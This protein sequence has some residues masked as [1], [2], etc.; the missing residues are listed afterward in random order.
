MSNAKL[1][2]LNKAVSAIATN[3]EA[4]L[5]KSKKVKSK[6]VEIVCEEKD[7][8][9][10]SS[11]NI[12]ES[13]KT[14][15]KKDDIVYKKL[16][17]HDQMLM[18]PD[19]YIGSVK[20]ARTSEPVFLLRRTASGTGTMASG[21]PYIVKDY[22][23]YPDGLIR[24][25]MEILSNAIDNVWRSVTTEGCN[26]T[27]IKI[28]IDRENGGVKVWNDGRNIPVEMHQTEKVYIPEMIFGHLLTSSNYNDGEER[29]TS[30]L[31]GVGAKASSVFSTKMNITIYNKAAGILYEQGWK[32]NMYEKGE[33][34]L[35]KITSKNNNYKTVEDGKNGF[36]QVEFFPD[37]SRFGLTRFT[38]DVIAI[39]EKLVYD[40]A[41]TVSMNKVKVQYNG[42]DIPVK[43]IKDYVKLYFANEKVT[44]TE[45]ESMSDDEELKLVDEPEP[46]PE[47]KKNKKKEIDEGVPSEHLLLASDDCR[48]MVCQTNCGEFTH[49]SFVNG[50]YTKYGGAHVDKW[51][52]ALFRPL[53]EK[54]NDNKKR[55]QIDI[56]DV[57][58]HFFI[59]VYASIDKPSFD[60]QSKNKLSDVPI[61][62]NVKKT[63]IAKMSK[64]EFMEKIENS[65]KMKEMLSLK[66]TERKKRGNVKVEGLD[67]AN[68]AGQKG[69]SQDCI[70]ALTEGLSAKTY[71]V[72]GMKYGING[73][74]G[75]DYI[76]VLPIRGKF[77]NVR[78]SSIET[79]IKNKEVKALIQALGLQYD[80]D[81]SVNE[82][83]N[84]LR[85]GKLLAVVDADSVTG[86]TPLLLKKDEMIEIKTIDDISEGEWISE[87]EKQYNKTSYQVWTEKGWTQIKHVMKHRT[88]KKLYRVVTHTGIVDVTEDHSLLRENGEE[89]EPTKIAINERLLHSYP[90]FTE[91]KKDI[92][93]KNIEDFKSIELQS[94]LRDHKIFGGGRYKKEEAF[95]KIQEIKNATYE[96]L[97]KDFKI[98][99]NE[100]WVMGFFWADGTCGVYK[101]QLRR[102]PKNRPNVYTLN[103]TNYSWC[104]SNTNIK[105]LEK[106]KIILE[107][108][109]PEYVWTIVEDRSN[110]KKGGNCKMAYRLICNGG[111][112]TEPII[113]KY[114]TLFYDSNK[115]KKIP[116]EILNAT[117]EIRSNFLEGYLYGDGN[118]ESDGETLKTNEIKFDIDGKIGASGIFF[119]CRSLGYLVS[120]NTRESKPKICSLNI[121]KGTQ[122]DHPNRIKKIIELGE[123]ETD[124]YDLETENHHFQAGVG[125]MIVH[126]T[127]G[128][129][130]NGLLMN[131]FHFLFPTLLKRNDFFYLMRVPILK[132][133][134]G[135]QILSFFYQ[136]EAQKYIEENKI[137]KDNIKYYKG[138]GTAN[139]DDI[140]QDF[141]RRL[142]QFNSDEKSD[143]LMEKIFGKENT[144]FRKDWISKYL[145]NEEE[146]KYPQIKDFSFEEKT[147][148]DYLNEEL[149]NF[150]IDDCHR[151]IP[152]MLDGFKES[153]RKVI[154]AA[155]KRP[156]RFSGKTLKVAQFAGYVAETSNYHH[157]EQNLYDTITKLAQRFVGSNNIPLL[158]NDGQ[159]GER[160]KNG[161]D[162]ANGR[163]IFTKLDALTR[164]IFREE[165]DT[166]LKNREDDGD[167]VE[168][169]H[170]LPIVP[171]ILVNGCSAGIGTGWSTSVPQYDVKQIIQAIKEWLK[172]GVET[173]LVPWYRNFK[174]EIKV[175]GTKIKTT[176]IVTIN[177]GE[178]RITE[179][180]LGRKNLSI[181]RYKDILEELKEK[182]KIKTIKD[183]ST[184]ANPDFVVVCEK[185][186]ELTVDDLQLID[187][188]STSNMVLFDSKG[189]IHRYENVE[190]ILE[191]FCETRL[192]LYKIRKEGVI[193]EFERELKY[194]RNKIRF[195]GEVVNSTISLKNR[196]DDDLHSELVQKKYDPLL[197]ED[198]NSELDFSYLLNI[199]VRSMTGQRLK[200]LQ[201]KE[202]KMQKELDEYRKKSEK[203]LWIGELDELS[204]EYDKW[205][206]TQVQEVKVTDVKKKVTKSKK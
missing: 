165:D 197:S 2:K 192:N 14:E 4:E 156:L 98:T 125:Q 73:K 70:C 168:K 180:P 46:S 111:I 136:Q 92:P 22:A 175:D 79:L 134:K 77:L 201:D 185:D 143:V 80:V 186:Q 11:V 205:V 85:Y 20:N 41:M 62:V 86:D 188:I 167:I 24:I 26:P 121:T 81:Y 184:E 59:F 10:T 135:K 63:D 203:D 196:T 16:Q 145:Q 87:G 124:V 15:K 39:Y 157:G 101:Y 48:V 64:W 126:N 123:I 146:Q 119:L 76:G 151:S 49:V 191:E 94:I 159:F 144:D 204:T 17:L 199:Q 50:I 139:D 173:K 95:K 27:L 118:K 107:E 84:K 194:L 65:L 174:G 120:V 30:G 177:S 58:K 43:S 153:H 54:L 108:I 61:Q 187:T 88:T 19:T 195:I 148:S 152:N 31:N 110:H 97:Q 114:R 162:A 149:I 104:I 170:Y 128:H 178:Y 28:W 166:F 160:I 38:D 9:E 164:L 18:R 3:K 122:Q 42:S 103:R 133:Q 93:D 23:T 56:R 55:Q 25:F 100:A 36:T 69:K 202:K 106:S 155:F 74:G 138:L 132:I 5:T 189:K 99:P 198:D 91:N 21:T 34:V 45:P 78:N 147:I 66:N 60:S 109:Y 57:K 193:K 176:G 141:G 83:F 52:E 150:S 171:M 105:Y 102:K 190:E 181:A 154:Y 44:E 96:N 172:G 163:Y 67:D 117:T 89:I 32:R 53:V 179:I 200:E 82:N 137:K 7:E 71:V 161:Q 90:Y 68:F 127:D 158:Y 37:F 40:C 142:V 51:S 206:I 116:L 47:K 169:E 140:K 112:K 13:F 183:Y 1:N 130:I 35:T 29:K 129:H 113:E 33:P 12:D 131:F 182:G 6:K 72:K 8:L 115:K 75:H